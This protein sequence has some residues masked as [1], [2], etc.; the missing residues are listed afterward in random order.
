MTTEVLNAAHDYNLP[1]APN[2]LRAPRRRP[3]LSAV[4]LSDLVDGTLGGEEIRK[5]VRTRDWQKAQD[6]VRRWEAEGATQY[7]N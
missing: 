2:S 4:P 1:A 6:I 5:S 7:K 3:E